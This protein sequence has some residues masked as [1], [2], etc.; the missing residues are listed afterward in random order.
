[1]SLASNKLLKTIYTNENP[2]DK[3]TRMGTVT[4]RKSVGNHSRYSIR[5]FGEEEENPDKYYEL[6]ADLRYAPNVGDRVILSKINSTYIITG[7]L[8]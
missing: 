5:F 2:N 6:I 1:M 4:G 3:Q 7:R 8:Y